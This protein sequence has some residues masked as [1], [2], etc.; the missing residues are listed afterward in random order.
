MPTGYTV[1]VATGELKSLKDYVECCIPAFMIHFRD[2]PNANI[3]EPLE[4]SCYCANHL[5]E[6]KKHMVIFWI[7]QM[8]LKKK[9]IMFMLII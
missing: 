5:A 8:L 2:S 7:C 1:K 4:L 6:L 3:R 9:L